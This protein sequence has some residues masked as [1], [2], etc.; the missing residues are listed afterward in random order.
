MQLDIESVVLTFGYGTSHEFFDE[1]N[2]LPSKCHATFSSSA[3][4]ASE[5]WVTVK[6][7]HRL[8]CT[9]VELTQ[10]FN[11]VECVEIGSIER[12]SSVMDL[13]AD[14]GSSLIRPSM[15]MAVGVERLNS[16]ASCGCVVSK[17][18]PDRLRSIPVEIFRGNQIHITK[19]ND[20]KDDHTRPGMEA[21]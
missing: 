4:V 9:E 10:V 11:V 20:G 1:R 2:F 18:V 17:P 7:C 5:V 21:N 12:S 15:P 16:K 14:E 3:A 6:R 13:E 19:V 8:D